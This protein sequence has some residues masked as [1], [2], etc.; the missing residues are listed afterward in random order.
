M[1][2]LMLAACCAAALTGC[3]RSTTSMPPLPK[4]S[5]PP[6]AAR[7]PCR[8]TPQQ[9]QPDGSATSADDDGTIRDG[10]FDLAA[11]DDKR[12]LLLDAWPR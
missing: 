6:A 11:W 7:E 10:R 5:D 1:R 8:P 9:R 4:I 2:N 12:R 3:A